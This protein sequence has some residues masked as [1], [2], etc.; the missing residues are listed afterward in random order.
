MNI[1]IN[2]ASNPSDESA[3]KSASLAFDEGAE[4]AKIPSRGEV[5]RNLYMGLIYIKAV[6]ERGIYF[7]VRPKARTRYLCPMSEWPDFAQLYEKEPTP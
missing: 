6:N 4:A 1:K 3:L 5:Y 2:M 7:T